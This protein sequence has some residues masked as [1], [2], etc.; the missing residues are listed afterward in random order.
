MKD[1]LTNKRNLEDL[2]TVTLSGNCS[3]IIQK[4]LPKKLTD[5]S[6]FII[7]CVIGEGM[8]ENALADSV[9][10]INVMLYNLFLKL[11]L[12]DLRPTRMTLQLV[13]QLVRRPRRVVEDVLIRVD[14][15]IIPVDFVI[16]DVDDDVKVLL[17]LE[18]PFLNTLGALIDIKGGKMTL[19]VG[20]EQ[21]VFTLPEAMKHTL[22]HDDTLYFTN[23][24]DLIISD[25]VQEVLA[26]NPLDEYL[27]EF[28]DKQ[29]EE[30][31]PLHQ[32]KK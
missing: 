9:A 4:K 22:D 18:R 11:G 10:S 5:P 29:I 24:T 28:R 14:K 26:M 31:T 6:S 1:L 2:E 32:Y 23:T 7:P 12:K 20:D 13:D 15:L 8:Q 21:V 19:R 30:E 17:I 3:T 16:L 25:C 27:E